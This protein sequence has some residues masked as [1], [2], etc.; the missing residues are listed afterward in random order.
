MSVYFAEVGQVQ[1]KSNKQ[2]WRISKRSLVL[3]V[4]VHIITKASSDIELSCSSALSKSV[5]DVH[6]VNGSLNFE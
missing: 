5:L 1:C 6:C 3:D 2:S 4:L